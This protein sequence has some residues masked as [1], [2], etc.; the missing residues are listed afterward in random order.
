MIT[1]VS[2][3]GLVVLTVNV[4]LVDPAGIVTLDG[5]VATTVLL[6]E[7]RTAT[8][9]TGAGALS[10]T[11]PVEESRPFTLVGFSVSAVS[12]T[13]AFGVAVG[14]TGSAVGV[15]VVPPPEG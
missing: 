6:L 11:V 7:S 9:P 14:V 8:P 5:T 10:I 4:L 12:V 15:G 2:D 3:C 1:E 13:L